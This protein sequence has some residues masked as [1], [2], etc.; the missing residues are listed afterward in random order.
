MDRF[1]P[2]PALLA[3]FQPTGDGRLHLGNLLGSALPFA[4]ARGFGSKFAMIA[5]AHAL[6][7]GRVPEGFR[8][9]KARMARELFAAG[10]GDEASLFEQSRVPELLALCALL[11]PFAQ[12]GELRRASHYEEKLAQSEGEPLALLA[13]P[14]LMSADILGLSAMEVA[15]GEDQRQHLEIARSISARFRE[16]SGVDLGQPRSAEIPCAMRAA[17]VKA[18]RDPAKKMSKSDPSGASTLYAVDSRG[19]ISRKLR[20]A[21]TDSMPLPAPG[22]PLDE[23][24]RPGAANLLGIVAACEGVSKEAALSRVA[25]LGH[26]ALKEMAVEAVDA[27]LAPIRLRFEGLGDAECAAALARGAEAARERAA[28]AYERARGA[29]G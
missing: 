2:T 23:A 20:K 13:Y 27:L 22:E 5:D 19:E 21:V 8:A 26:G 16:R 10:A 7:L 17:R 4:H 25:G 12:L 18:L 6:S 14:C 29:L 24:E 11:A 3:G 1:K 15:V 9:A 28:A